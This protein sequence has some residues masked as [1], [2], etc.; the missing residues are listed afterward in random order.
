[1]ISFVKK[2]PIVALLEARASPSWPDLRLGLLSIS[3]ICQLDTEFV[4][5]GQAC[6]LNW[7]SEAGL[8]RHLGV[9]VPILAS[10]GG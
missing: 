7:G 2:V 5:K 9:L 6:H 1:M 4:I 3:S 10:L 8:I